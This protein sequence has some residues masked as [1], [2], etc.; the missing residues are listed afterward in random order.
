MVSY[1]L[2]FVSY[3]Y[4]KEIVGGKQQSHTCML[5]FAL[6]IDSTITHHPKTTP[7]NPHTIP[8]NLH[9]GFDNVIISWAGVVHFQRCTPNI[10][11]VDDI[12]TEIKTLSF[13]DKT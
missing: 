3:A 10:Q 4:H 13:R 2:P 11:Y 12:A 6:V 7:Y 5:A 1:T 9:Q 8:S